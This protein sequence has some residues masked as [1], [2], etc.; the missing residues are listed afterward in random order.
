MKPSTTSKTSTSIATT[1]G[2]IKKEYRLPKTLKPFFYDLKVL[3]S[4]DVQTEPNLFDGDLIIKFTC[5]ESTNL[6]SFHKDELEIIESSI[7]ITN[8]ESEFSF[9]STSYDKDTQIYKIELTQSLTSN[10]N[11]SISMKYV[12]KVQA[13]NFGFYKS[14]YTDSNGAKRY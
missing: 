4:F 12:G 14:F 6:I 1:T 2:N 11:Y 10:K 3:T 9:S 5:I 7:K 8:E 13:N